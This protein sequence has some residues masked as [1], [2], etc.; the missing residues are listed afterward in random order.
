MALIA[1][2]ARRTAAAAT[3]HDPHADAAGQVAEELGHSAREHD[4]GTRE[5]VLRLIVAQGPVAAGDLADAL[6][7]T[8]PAVR[9]HLAL[10]ESEG[11]IVARQAVGH[12]KR[13]R[14]RPAK[15]YVATESA[16]AGLSAATADLA[17]QA[18]EYLAR[19]AGRPSVEGF[20]E[21]RAGALERRYRPVLDQAD[22]QPGARAQALARALTADGYEATTRPVA[23]AVSI[24]LCQGHCPV[25]PVATAFPELCEA[26]T[27]AFSRLLGVH[28]Q[29]LATL[30]GGGHACTTSIPTHV[31]PNPVEGPR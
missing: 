22:P 11:Q 5:H 18:L 24:Q 19:V 13:G 4:A 28:V 2:P 3:S 6:G 1:Q 9:R 25:R 14:G 27:R 31:P 12:A 21:D 8:A 17:V 20:A 30:A 16:H 15:N 7:L 10:L 29:R 23:G 26:E